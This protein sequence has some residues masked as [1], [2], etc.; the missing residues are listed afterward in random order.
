MGSN[1]ILKIRNGGFGRYLLFHQTE[2]QNKTRDIICTFQN[3]VIIT[4]NRRKT[5]NTVLQI[6]TSEAQSM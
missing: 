6:P 4:V 3:L 5:P 1:F 2:K